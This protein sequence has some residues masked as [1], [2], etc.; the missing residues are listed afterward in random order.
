V[1]HGAL[2]ASQG[3]IERRFETLQD[4]LVTEMRV[5]EI[6]SIEQANRFLQITFWSAWSQRLAVR[7]AQSSDAHRKLQRQQRLEQILSV[8]VARVDTEDQ[9]LA[10]RLK[11][12]DFVGL[13]ETWASGKITPSEVPV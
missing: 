12:Y 1:N 7:P 2:P 5:M 8:R 10:R 6:A 13:P 3:R 9:L 11:L 4:R